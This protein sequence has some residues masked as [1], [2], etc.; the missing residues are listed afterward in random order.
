MYL[1]HMERLTG[2]VCHRLKV[3]QG[4]GAPR[5]ID[6]RFLFFLA[7][8]IIALDYSIGSKKE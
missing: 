6:Y 7:S 8:K 1:S 2:K 3:K 5:N 4:Y